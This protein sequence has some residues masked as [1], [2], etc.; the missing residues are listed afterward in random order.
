MR[1]NIPNIIKETQTL[2]VNRFDS[3]DLHPMLSLADDT[4]SHLKR[5]GLIPLIAIQGTGHTYICYS[6]KNNIY[7]EVDDDS[8][9]IFKKSK[10]INDLVNPYA[11]D[12]NRR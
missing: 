12:L 10:N 4:F 11:N 2:K 5:K 3:A 1:P 6:I 9:Q 7:V 8:M